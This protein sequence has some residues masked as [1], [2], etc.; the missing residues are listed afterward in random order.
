MILE[1]IYFNLRN[2]LISHCVNICLLHLTLSIGKKIGNLGVILKPF[3]D[4]FLQPLCKNVST[5]TLNKVCLTYVCVGL[6]MDVLSIQIY[7]EW[8]KAGGEDEGSI[9]KRVICLLFR[10]IFL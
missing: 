1:M 10:V 4:V 9:K 8:E 5:S 2:N 3:G 6:K 7:L